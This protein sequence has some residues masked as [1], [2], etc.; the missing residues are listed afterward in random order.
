MCCTLRIERGAGEVVWSLQWGEVLAP[1]LRSKPGSPG[2]HVNLHI[3][4]PAPPYDIKCASPP[5]AQ[6]LLQAVQR[7]LVSLLHM[8][9]MNT[10]LNGTSIED[11]ATP[12]EQ[13]LLFAYTFL[14]A[15]YS[16]HIQYTCTQ[17]QDHD[18]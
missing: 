5:Q 6:Q 4:M 10:E 7:Q 3:R 16:I 8:R 15:A 1:E 9:I 2:E 17:N 18:K 11:A 13:V 14:R 12:L